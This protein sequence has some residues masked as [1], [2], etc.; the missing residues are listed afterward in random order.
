MSKKQFKQEVDQLIKEYIQRLDNNAQ[1]KKILTKNSEIIELLYDT[2]KYPYPKA[3]SDKKYEKEMSKLQIELVKSQYYLQKSGTKVMILFEGRDA[4]KGGT[5]QRFMMNINPR[6]ARISALDIPTDYERGQWYFQRYVKN[7]PSSGEL[8]LSDRSW[9]NRAGVEHVMGFCSDEE[10]DIFMEQVPQFE[11]ML[12]QSGVILIK[13]WLSIDK[14][15]QLRRFRKRQTSELRRW[16]LSPNDIEA[17]D[18]WD[19]Y[20]K[21][22]EKIFKQTSTKKSPWYIVKTDDKNRGRIECIR[23]YLSLID[24]PDKDEE[25]VN[26]VDDSICYKA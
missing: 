10:Y 1:D 3:M 2:G 7:L 26:K 6:H 11:H 19:D 15:E 14:L 17:I 24:Y 20:T 23:H 12:V 18:K 16:K 21:A 9:Y 25:L 5:I 4:G 8:V 13:Y 22:L